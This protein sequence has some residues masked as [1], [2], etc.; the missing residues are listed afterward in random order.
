M[1]YMRLEGFLGRTVSKLINKGI[2]AK[3]G[4]KP[5]IIV[6]N[7]NLR[8]IGKIEVDMLADK[9]VSKNDDDRIVLD[10]SVSMSQDDFNKLIEEVTK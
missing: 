8:T 1:E 7:L 5:S 3:L 4:Y 6:D 10:L 9:V 2:E